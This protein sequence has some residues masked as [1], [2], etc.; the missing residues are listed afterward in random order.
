[1]SLSC[2]MCRLS[3][4]RFGKYHMAGITI[5]R[6]C[7]IPIQNRR[8]YM[9]ELNSLFA[10]GK[11]KFLGDGFFREPTNGVSTIVDISLCHF[12]S[13]IRT[14]HI[15]TPFH[16]VH[17]LPHASHFSS[18]VPDTHPIIPAVF[19]YLGS[20]WIR[21]YLLCQMGE[22]L[23]YFYFYKICTVC[24]DSKGIFLFVQPKNRLLLL[25]LH[26]LYK[27]TFGTNFNPL[28]LYT[29]A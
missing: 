22:E 26:S 17:I 27:P 4:Y 21:G 24:N 12:F 9:G 23:S 5:V 16:K 25:L 20:W 8:S 7:T 18:W 19:L 15:H 14:L 10:F 6:F 29:L 1:M 2:C 13:T 28:F 3:F 11:G